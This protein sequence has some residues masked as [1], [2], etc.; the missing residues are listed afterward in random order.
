MSLMR[1]LA[2][3]GTLG[4]PIRLRGVQLGRAV[5]ALL[6]PEDWRLVGYEVLCGDESSRFLPFSTAE[7]GDD[8]I[9]I[10]S[11]LLLLEDLGFYRARAR[12]AR[13]L[14]GA[15]VEVGG[16]EPGLLRDLV[17]DEKGIVVE[18]VLEDDGV[19]RRIR[20]PAARQDAA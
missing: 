3:E 12:S 13:A 8:A 20:P 1:A 19:E 5:D 16:A 9:R 14:L 6:D 17:V 15:L 7:V 2:V 11:A 18:L 10:G 4:L